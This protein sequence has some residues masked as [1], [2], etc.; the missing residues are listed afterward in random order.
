M[1]APNRPS[2]HRDR[3]RGARRRRGFAATALL[4]LF[5]GLLAGFA[6]TTANAESSPPDIRG[7]SNPF[8]VYLN[9][10]ESV[11][12]ESD[13]LN[14]VLDQDGNPVTSGDDVYGPATADG[15]W[16]VDIGDVGVAGTTAAWTVTALDSGGNEISG[17]VWSEFYLNVQAGGAAAEADLDFWVVNDSGYA[18][19]VS[20]TDFNGIQS[21]IRADAIGNPVALDDCTP[22]Y[23]S[24]EFESPGSWDPIPDCGGEYR[25]FF[26]EPAADLPASANLAGTEVL[27]APEPLEEDDLAVNDFDY[28]QAAAGSAAGDF[29]WSI[30][31]R[32][33]GAY[34]LEID[35][36]GDGEFDGPLDRQILTYADG[37]GS[38]SE[39][40]DG[41]DG[42]G[43]VIGVCQD[44]TT[45]LKYD[46]VGEVHFVQEDVESRAGG[47]EVTR[48]S[49]PGSPD[50]TLY[51]DDTGLADDRTNITPVLD[52]TAGVDSTGGVHGWEFD[53][54]S[55]GNN[56]V[57][58]DWAYAPLLDATTAQSTWSTDCD[59]GLRLTK[60]SDAAEDARPGD[61]VTYTV[62]ATN[63]GDG[64]F[65]AD[66]PAVVV[67]DLTGVLDDATY[68]DDAAADQ[69]GDLGFAEPNLVWS[70]PLAAGDSVT[71]EYTVTL[72]GGG[73]GNVRNVAWAPPPTD[74]PDEWEPPACDPPDADGLDPDTGLPCAEHEFNLPKLSI[75][76]TASSVELPAVGQELTYTVTLTNE[77]PGDYTA[78]APASFTD[79]L[80]DVLDDAVLDE[81]S[82][83]VTGGPPADYAAPELSWSGP[84]ASGDSVIIEYTVTYTGEGD[85]LLVN[86][87][88]I[89]ADEV[90]AGD[91][92]CDEVNVPGALIDPYKTAVPSSTPL[93]AGSTVTYTLWFDNEG[94]AAGD[95]DAVDHLEYVL[96]DAELVEGPEGE[97]GLTATLAG[98][99]I[100]ITGSV[101]AGERRSVTYVVQILPDDQRGDNRLVN[102]LLDDE[103]EPPPPPDPNELCEDT[104]TSTCNDVGEI[105]PTKSV[106]PQS[107]TEVEAGDR[108]TY[109]LSFVNTGPA[110]AVDYVDHLADVL[111]D[112]DLVG[113][114]Q[115]TGGLEVS[116][117]TDGLLTITG[118]VGPGETAQ[119]VYTVEVKDDDD[120]GND[121]LANFLVPDGEDPPSECVDDN[122][123][124][125]SNLIVPGGDGPS[126]G[127]LLPV[128][129]GPALALLL[130]ALTMI[131]AGYGA[132]TARR[133][134]REDTGGSVED[135]LG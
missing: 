91:V 119:V 99:Q 84:L 8:F 44:F 118:I 67:D 85:Q 15:I 38:Y 22:S 122:S 17:R 94:Q 103:E 117:P 65:T 40:F 11:H 78:D 80:S 5:A 32:F 111:D 54:N 129:G 132:L 47:I 128:T 53:G 75:N 63:V 101:P 26:A 56:R 46:R 25:I 23:R 70:G 34:V 43:N 2:D 48:L 69:P 104:R 58:D 108:L 33:T 135:L 18:Y 120:R 51:W 1:R 77:G 50:T 20:F 60:T 131:A 59:P 112:A 4:S 71:I 30:D 41:L 68:N 92:P 105:L 45:R 42:A 57:I 16:Q 125:T 81:D 74:P 31:P 28:E 87:A 12:A 124:C 102:H 64:D 6:A 39:T 61:T 130:L 19:A 66:E 49:G 121:Q 126:P 109:T 114:P 9:A 134:S 76:K 79:D 93:R 98:D 52:G 10:G 27:V 55:W 82:I 96:D 107:G 86:T 115:A 37:S 133:R 100:L 83:T 116:G 14:V 36:D 62:T 97:A 106:D 88:C 35:V 89:P 72:A 90:A 110:T 127:G 73:D 3:H 113:E 13:S 24:K 29:T 7:A 95:V 123:L 21:R